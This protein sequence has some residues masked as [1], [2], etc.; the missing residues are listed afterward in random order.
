MRSSSVSL[1][2]SPSWN[3]STP[4][5]IPADQSETSIFQPSMRMTK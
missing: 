5:G 3:D 1:A 4:G 2:V